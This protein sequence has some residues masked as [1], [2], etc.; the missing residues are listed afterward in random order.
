LVDG[1][2]RQR[3]G[4][5]V[6]DAVLEHLNLGN[7]VRLGQVADRPG[8]AEHQRWKRQDREKGR[9]AG[10]PGDPVGEARGRGARCQAAQQAEGDLD[11]R[12]D[13]S[14]GAG[15]ARGVVQPAQV[16]GDYGSHMRTLSAAAIFGAV[17]TFSSALALR[18][19]DATVAVAATAAVIAFVTWLSALHSDDA[20]SGL[21]LSNPAAALTLVAVRRSPG[22]AVLP[23]IAAQV[24]GSVAGGFAALG[25][26]G[27]LGGA[28]TW[29]DPKLLATGVVVAFLGV[30]GAWV[31]LAIDG[32]DS[33]AWSAVPPLASAAALGVGL[34]AALNPAVV[35][36]LATAGIV[37][38][39]TAGIAAVAGLI[40]AFAGAYLVS[41]VT[42]REATAD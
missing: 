7:V 24:V 4:R 5:E 21:A 39:I 23:L 25:L 30:L 1:R 26:A 3:L 17:T 35:L 41:A 8:Q 27:S 34:T 6:E 2:R 9:L 38:W 20:T 37:S 19:P 18:A 42:P 40:A 28:L 12:P 22:S 33:A 32:G 16:H 15:P 31:T 29:S 36:G 13:G 10:E 14:Q 11:S